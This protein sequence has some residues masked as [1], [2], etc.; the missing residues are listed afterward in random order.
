MNSQNI[1][2]LK[3]MIS[4]LILL[5]ATTSLAAFA[6]SHSAKDKELLIHV[7]P[8]THCAIKVAPSDNES[9]CALLYSESKNPCKNDPECVCSKKE[10]Y[11]AWQTTTGDAFD[12]RFTQGS[13]FKRCEYQAGAD[14]EV[15]CKIK[16]SGDYYYEVNVKG[17]ATNPYDPR[18]VVQ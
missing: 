14:G 5:I 15:R 4:G 9:N 16:N 2:L 11:I 18:I 3:K 12:I 6:D 17:C 7:D 10:K 8:S 13:P 1:K